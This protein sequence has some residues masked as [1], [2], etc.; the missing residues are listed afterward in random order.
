MASKLLERAVHHQLY[1]F[2]NEHKLVSPFQ[3]GFKSNHSTEFT[4]VAFSD[5]VRR[6]MDQGLLTGAVFIDL[7]KAFHS[8]DHDLLINKLESYGLKNTELNWFKSYLSDRKQ[9][10]RIGQETSDYCPITSG[11]SPRINLRSL[12]VC[13]ILTKCQ[14][15]MYADDTVMYFSATDSQV[16]ADTLTNEL[17]LVNKWLIDNNLFLHKGKTECML[18]GTG[19]RLALSTSF[20][21]AIDGKA[22]NRV[23]EYKYLGVVL[24][25][26]LT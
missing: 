26:S 13:F 4:A 18:F 15:L 2:C 7:R 12:I 6:G 19:P 5:F 24:D 10:V 8:V 25:V 3:C 11:V 23:S 1:S 17:A 21:I 9:V 22:L 14:I 20:S 16:I